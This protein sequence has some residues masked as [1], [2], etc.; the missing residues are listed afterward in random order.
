[1]SGPV[2]SYEMRTADGR[3]VGSAMTMGF[4]ADWALLIA[5]QSGRAVTIDRVE[6]RREAV[7]VPP[8][9]PR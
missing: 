8:A 3:I 6:R 5:R 9:P 1:M 4:A 2:V 7:I